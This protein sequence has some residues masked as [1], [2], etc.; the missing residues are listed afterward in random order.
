MSWAKMMTSVVRRGGFLLSGS[1]LSH[2]SAQGLLG[3]APGSMVKSS[4][5]V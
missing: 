1:C 4:V 2:D 5:L 3:V